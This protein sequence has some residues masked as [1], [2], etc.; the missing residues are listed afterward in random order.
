M[1]FDEALAARIRTAV[2][3]WPS[4]EERR[5]FGGLAFLLDGSMFCG[6]TGD[7]LLVRV[8]SDRNDEDLARPHVR[9]MD[10]TGKPMKGY[11]YVAPAGVAD[12]AS[13]REW[14]EEGAAFVRTLPRRIAK[15]TS[16]TRRRR[17]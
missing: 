2:A 9:P 6:I 5:M 7:E 14:V 8:G 3:S 11:V 10:F 1:A 13:L 4:V 12:D 16:G 15:A 17:R